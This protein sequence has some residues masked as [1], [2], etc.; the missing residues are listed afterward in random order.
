MSR[1]KYRNKREGNPLCK[2]P[3]G[4]LTSCRDFSIFKFFVFVFYVKIGIW[5]INTN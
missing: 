2:S 1:M 4:I 3:W 5:L